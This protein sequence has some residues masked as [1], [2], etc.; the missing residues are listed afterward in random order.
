MTLINIAIYEFY[1][2]EIKKNDEVYSL[3]LGKI[4]NLF[5]FHS[6]AQIIEPLNLEMGIIVSKPSILCRML[7]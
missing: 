7:D 6:E 5:Q 2:I 4:G 1:G 3:I